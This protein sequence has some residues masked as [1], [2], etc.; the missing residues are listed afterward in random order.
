MQLRMPRG[1]V[2]SPRRRGYAGNRAARQAFFLVFLDV[3][4]AQKTGLPTAVIFSVSPCP[5]IIRKIIRPILRGRSEHLIALDN[6]SAM[7]AR[8]VLIFVRVGR[9]DPGAARRQTINQPSIGRNSKHSH[10]HRTLARRRCRS[11]TFLFAPRA[12]LTRIGGL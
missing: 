4:T 7:S 2:V 5:L 9:D 1:Q 6:S 8:N 12:R 3:S 11:D 10:A